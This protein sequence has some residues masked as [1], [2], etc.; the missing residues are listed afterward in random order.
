M[1]NM[2]SKSTRISYNTLNCSIRVPYE[3]IFTILCFAFFLKNS[4]IKYD[5]HF[6]GGENFLKIGESSLFRDPVGRKF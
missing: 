3:P 6:L 4:K 2:V 1:K 5:P